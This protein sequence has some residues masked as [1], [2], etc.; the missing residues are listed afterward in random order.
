MYIY[1]IKIYFFHNVTINTIITDAG[2]K[3]NQRNPGLGSEE[4]TKK[5]LVIIDFNAL[6]HSFLDI[7]L[8]DSGF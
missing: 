2:F 1:W 4:T 8:L 6:Y 7:I 3:I 5:H